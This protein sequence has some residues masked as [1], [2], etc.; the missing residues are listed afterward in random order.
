M[1]DVSDIFIST[2]LTDTR[3]FFRNDVRERV[4]VVVARR[5]DLVAHD[6]VAR[7]VLPISIVR[8]DVEARRAVAHVVDQALEI[9]R[10]ERRLGD[11]A[12][13][14]R[15]FGPRKRLD[16]PGR[17]VLRGVAQE[18]EHLLAVLIRRE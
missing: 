16:L 10:V 1:V 8:R 6:V 7:V 2:W 12:K 11:A 14:R 13:A 17:R 9:I 18:D 5:G 15:R 3:R 4:L